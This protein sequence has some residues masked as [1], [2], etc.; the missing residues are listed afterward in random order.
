M[1]VY[2]TLQFQTQ[3]T[4]KQLFLQVWCQWNARQSDA[5]CRAKQA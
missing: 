2:M 4:K 3:Y 5:P 1:Y